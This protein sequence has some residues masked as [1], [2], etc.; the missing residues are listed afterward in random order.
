MAKPVRLAV[1][2]YGLV[3]RRHVEA[4]S[5]TDAANV[6]CVIEPDESARQEA[7]ATGFQ[8]FDSLESFV[9][10]A[11]ADGIILATPSP[12]HVDQGL[13]CVA[14]GLPVLVEKPIATRAADADKLVNAA[15]AAGVPLLV[16]HHRRHNR[17]IGRAKAL[18]DEGQVGTI[19]AVQATC[20]FYKPDAYFDAAPWR[21]DAGAGPV[22]VNLVHD[23]DVLR[24]LCGE[25]TSVRAVARPSARGHANEDVASALLEFESGAVGTI[26]VSD[27][28]VAPYSWEM[29]SREYPVYPPVDAT[30]C[31]IG[32]SHGTLSIP[33]LKLWCYAD[34]NRDWWVPLSV[35]KID[36]ASSDPL[37]N[38]I[39]NFA[40]VINGKETPIV[41]GAEGT[42]TLRVVESIQDAARTGDCVMLTLRQ[43]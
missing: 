37:V 5:K 26:N 11:L 9:R 14:R 23:V 13:A 15:E 2:G 24:Y 28:I 36:Y 25:V 27:A 18:I 19:R 3:G 16:G 39:E 32:G 8:V 34:G 7:E 10:E 31:V 6:A 33:D 40:Q 43:R 38:Q 29:T 17:L 22:S 41:S 42:R 4:I 20:W 21:K 35:S 12:M 1:A 30:C